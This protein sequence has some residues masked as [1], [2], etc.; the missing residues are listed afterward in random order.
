MQEK[1]EQIPDSPEKVLVEEALHELESQKDGE[2][3]VEKL[4]ESVAEVLPDAV[5]TIEAVQTA[6]KE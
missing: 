5:E 2:S 3:K 1:L 6:I 4:I